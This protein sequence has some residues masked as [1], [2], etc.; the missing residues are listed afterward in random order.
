MKTRAQLLDLQRCNG[1]FASK[2]TPTGVHVPHNSAGSGRQGISPRMA[3][4][5]CYKSP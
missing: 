2:L 4:P 5:Q 1:V 3:M